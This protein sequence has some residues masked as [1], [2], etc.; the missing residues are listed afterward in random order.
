M[1]R[2][3]RESY[4]ALSNYIFYPNGD[5][6]RRVDK[7]IGVIGRYGMVPYNN[8]YC[9]LLAERIWY[10]PYIDDLSIHTPCMVSIPFFSCLLNESM[11]ENV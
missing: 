10:L 11:Y 3:I 6:K 5:N 7:K 1:N 8:T 4:V 2:K 9:T